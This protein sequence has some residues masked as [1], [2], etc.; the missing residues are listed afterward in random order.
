MSEKG[1]EG[2]GEEAWGGGRAGGWSGGRGGGEGADRSCG[3][4]NPDFP[5]CEEP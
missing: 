4:L 3:P 2:E 5:T 1:G